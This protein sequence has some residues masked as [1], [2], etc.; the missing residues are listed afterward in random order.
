VFR[1]GSA[2]LLEPPRLIKPKP[3]VPHG[4]R[5][6]RPRRRPGQAPIP[7]RARLRRCRARCGTKRR[8]AE[9][10]PRAALS[11]RSR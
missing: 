9:C 11:G 7:A 8:S 5:S 1:A 3:T 6:F 10:R 4:E 2:T